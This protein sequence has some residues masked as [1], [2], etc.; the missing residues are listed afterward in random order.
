MAFARA[1]SL[2]GL[3]WHKVTHLG[4]VSGGQWFASMFAFDE[5]LFKQLTDVSG[6][7]PTPMREILET[8]GRRF[9]RS[10]ADIETY[11]PEIGKN[12]QKSL[13][14]I[15]SYVNDYIANQQSKADHNDEHVQSIT[16][17]WNLLHIHL[18]ET[19]DYSEYVAHMLR[20]YVAGLGGEAVKTYEQMRTL[21][22]AGL[23][24]ASLVQGLGLP[25]D[26]WHNTAPHQVHS[27]AAAVATP[28]PRGPSAPSP[29]CTNLVTLCQPHLDVALPGH[30]AGLLSAR[31]GG[32]CRG[33]G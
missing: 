26:V 21:T 32:E 23:R 12:C 31:G 27:P 14:K 17:L 10:M 20:E 33:Q 4:G 25:A 8:F 6:G 13:E 11:Q 3:E 15:E 1:L 19:L 2:A 24:T 22:H 9:R 16:V 5:A 7:P 29:P 30:V 28:P 18:S